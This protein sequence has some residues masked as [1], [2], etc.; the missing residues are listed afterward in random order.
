ML[1][2]GLAERHQACSYD[3]ISNSYKSRPRAQ[4]QRLQN[5]LAGIPY[6]SLFRTSSSGSGGFGIPL[7]SL[8]SCIYFQISA[9]VHGNQSSFFF[10]SPQRS[11]DHLSAKYTRSW[12]FFFFF[13]GRSTDLSLGHL[14]PSWEKKL[15]IKNRDQWYQQEKEEEKS[16][17]I[18]RYVERNTKIPRLEWNVEPP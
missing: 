17:T 12:S 6:Y 13:M 4:Y 2:P 10:F 7:Q 1:I 16:C 8:G 5:K 15:I 3:H 9:T 18:S 14:W 11:T